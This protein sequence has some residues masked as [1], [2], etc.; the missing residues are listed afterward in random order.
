M[1][2][3]FQINTLLLCDLA[4]PGG[5]HRGKAFPVHVGQSVCVRA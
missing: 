2:S 3:D 1:P 5:F 4:V